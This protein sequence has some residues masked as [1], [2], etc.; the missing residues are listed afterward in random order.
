[1][2]LFAKPLEPT[3][4][5]PESESP[6]ESMI[7]STSSP[8]DDSNDSSISS[9]FPRSPIYTGIQSPTYSEPYPLINSQ[10]GTNKVLFQDSISTTQ[11]YYSDEEQEEDDDEEYMFYDRMMRS[12]TMKTHISRC[13]KMEDCIESFDFP[14]DIKSVFLETLNRYSKR[15]FKEIKRKEEDEEV[16]RYRKRCKIE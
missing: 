4:V 6:P 14:E 9:Y 16:M 11:S 3:Y 5:P 15:K 8:Q 10:Y 1:M 2:D 13:I 7:I 12:S